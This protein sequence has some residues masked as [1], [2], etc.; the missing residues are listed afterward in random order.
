MTIRSRLEKFYDEIAGIL[1]EKGLMAFKR[2][3]TE[4][5]LTDAQVEDIMYCNSKALLNL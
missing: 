2:V 3:A 1:E 5:K 4:L